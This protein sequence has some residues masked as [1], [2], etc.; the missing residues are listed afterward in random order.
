M[1]GREG[2]EMGAENAS[3]APDAPCP[4]LVPRGGVSEVTFNNPKKLSPPRARRV[5]SGSWTVFRG[6]PSG[7]SRPANLEFG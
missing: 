2:K 7:V 5:F 6:I 1:R 3:Q 4:R